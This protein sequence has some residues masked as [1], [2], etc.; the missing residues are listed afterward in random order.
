M[1]RRSSFGEL[2][3]K[4]LAFIL[5]GTFASVTGNKGFVTAKPST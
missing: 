4:P 2:R 3:K 1:A 5:V